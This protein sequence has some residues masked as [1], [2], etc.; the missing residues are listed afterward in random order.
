MAL[1]SVI[2]SHPTSI[3]PSPSL[4]AAYVVAIFLGQIGYCILLVIARKPETKVSSALPASTWSI[5]SILQ[6]TLVKA[7]GLSLVFANWLMALWA[8]SWV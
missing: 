3:S 2:K 8:I 7:V 4:I 6:T 5:L 1:G